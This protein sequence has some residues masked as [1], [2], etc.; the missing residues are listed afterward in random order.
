MRSAVRGLIDTAW[1][2]LVLETSK[3]PMPSVSTRTRS[4]WKPRRTGRE[5]LGPNDVADTPGWRA[6]V[7]PIVGRISRAS[8]S[9]LTTV[10][11]ERRSARLWVNG[12]DNRLLLGR[13]ILVAAPCL[14]VVLVLSRLARRRGGGSAADAS[15]LIGDRR[16]RGVLSKRNSGAKRGDRAAKQQTRE[17]FE[18]LPPGGREPSIRL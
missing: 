5:A 9:P 15:I 8:S 17:Q 12:D 2:T 10:V 14:R 3:L 18:I 7:S 13:M 1:S 6:S 4:P 11:P 16:G